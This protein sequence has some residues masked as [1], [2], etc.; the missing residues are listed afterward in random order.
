MVEQTC[1][2]VKE[3]AVFQRGAE[4][5]IQANIY[6]RKINTIETCS[7]GNGKTDEMVVLV[8]AG[9]KTKG[10]QR[11]GGREQS[12]LVRVY[13]DAERY[14]FSEGCVKISKQGTGSALYAR[15]LLP[16]PESNGRPV[17]K[18]GKSGII[19]IRIEKDLCIER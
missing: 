3:D 8:K 13:V 2:S 4:Y 15:P 5:R 12:P 6:L 17:F 7:T 11:V 10:Q 1:I 19:E 14:L 18:S 16:A 9:F